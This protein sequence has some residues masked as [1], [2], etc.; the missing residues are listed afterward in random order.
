MY[1]VHVVVGMGSF[2]STRNTIY[3][4]DDLVEME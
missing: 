2:L 1:P 4:E 3:H